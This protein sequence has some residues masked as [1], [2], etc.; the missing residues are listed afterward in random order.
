MKE[1]FDLFASTGML[2]GMLET[3][4]MV[5]FSTVLSYI[6]GLP[7]GVLVVVSDKN[8]I[9]PNRPVNLILGTFINLFRSI[10]F[11]ILLVL[12]IPFTRLIVGT[13]IGSTAMIVPLTLAATT[14]VARLVET[15]LREID[16][17]VIE[18]A[19]TMGATTL[20]IVFKVYLVEATPALIRGL[21][22]T[23]INLIGY[24]AMAGAV[25]GGGL[26][27]IAIRFGYYKYNYRVMIITVVFLVAIVQL[28]QFI[29]DRISR[30]ID[31]KRL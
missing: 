18:Q 30:K 10:P 21:A 22:I 16:C 29:F 31:K 24:S 9:K 17:G 28:I 12:L 1:F 7:L 20:Q 13:S 14:F 19:L 23:G 26:G 2:K 11:L 3:L 27:D 25:A 4:Y 5:S 8:G 15:S 6:L